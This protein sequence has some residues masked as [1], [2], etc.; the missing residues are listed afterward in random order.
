MSLLNH[1][2]AD[3]NAGLSIIPV[4]T[5]GTKAPATAWKKNQTTRATNTQLTSWFGPHRALGVVTGAVSGQLEMLELEGR[6]INEGILEAFA[7]ALMDNGFTDLWDRIRTGWVEISPS[8]GFHW[9]YRVDGKAQPNTKLARRPSTA[10]EL[11]SK[12]DEKIKVLIETRGEGGFVVLAPSIGHET[13]KAWTRLS[14][15]PANCPVITEDERDALYAIANTLD[16]MP[17]AEQPEPAPRNT[18]LHPA[19]ERPGD[20]YNARADWSDI[21]IPLGWTLVHTIGRTRTWRR[22]GK[23]DGIS[24]TTGRNDGDNLYV[25]TTSTEFESEKPYSKFGAYTLLEHN[26]DW[27]AAAKALGAAGYGK[28]LEPSHPVSPMTGLPATEGN[29]A[30][31]HTLPDTQPR[32]HLEA[33]REATLDRSDDGNALALVDTFGERIRYCHDRGK[34]LAWDGQRWQWC[35]RGGGVIREYAK[36]IARALPE[37]D[38]AAVTHKRRSLGAIGTTAMLTQAATDNRISV[39]LSELDAHP[40]DLNTP[41]G[42]VD[43]R[44]GLVSPPDPARLHTRMTTCTPSPEADPTRWETFLHDTFGDDNDLIGF[45]RRVVGYSSIGAVGTHV[46]PFCHGSGGNGKGVFLEAIGKV[47]G[48]YATTAPS[49]FLMK[50]AYAK[51]ET[52]IARLAGARMV[53]CSEVNEDD[54]FDEAKVKQLTG[55]DTLTAR[56]MQQ[57]HFTFT[58]TH[59]LWLMGNHKPSVRSGGDSFWRRVRLIEFR[60]TVPASKMIDD[61]QGILASDHGAALLHWIVTG[62]AEYHRSGLLAPKTVLAATA[63]YAHDQDTVTR[64]LEEGCRRGGGEHV[65]VKVTRVRE[66]YEQWCRE[67]GEQP[68]T[69]KAFGMA[70]QKRGICATKG[71]QGQRFYRGLMLLTEEEETS[72]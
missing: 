28:P 33:V 46:L 25:F 47:L 14:G 5:D 42:I 50:Q 21:L 32:P 10:N 61:L 36:R 72:W 53:L 67:A 3:S 51:H 55:G 60:H 1:A 63:D 54:D 34:W 27:K 70:L 29:L 62:A 69:A 30:T 52:E 56:F 26:G 68:V 59:Q 13:G 40:W 11:A 64:F 44:T 24:A 31:I 65:Q 71:S 23:N 18:S 58:P 15:G 16:T 2:V 19:G 35:E 12:P 20:D 66:S 22:P 57:D 17:V 6:A 8:G 37:D 48:D 45:L 43:L 39:S 7:E 9:F 41:A 49:G 38:K 4:L